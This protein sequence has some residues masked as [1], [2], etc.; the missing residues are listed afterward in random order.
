MQRLAVNYLR[1]LLGVVAYHDPATGDVVDSKGRII[2]SAD[3]RDS[4]KAF[5]KEIEWYAKSI[6]MFEGRERMIIWC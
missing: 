1:D 3:S 4:D 2:V 6:R 5:T